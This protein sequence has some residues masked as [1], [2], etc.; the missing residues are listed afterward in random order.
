MTDDLT[1]LADT[2]GEDSSLHV[3]LPGKEDTGQRL[4]RYLAAQFPDVSR[5]VLQ[6]L[7]G[8]ELVT[9]DGVPRRQVFKVTA[10]QVI[11]VTLPEA[12]QTDLIAEPM[13]L[14]VIYQDED[15][16]VLDKPAG[17]VVHPAPGNPSGTLVN[18][19]LHYLPNLQVGGTNRPGIVHR[20]DKETSGVMVVGI[21]DRGHRSL[22]SQWANRTVDKRYTALVRGD[23]EVDQGTID[24][25]IGRHSTDR[26]RMAPQVAGKTAVS[27]FTVL[28]R[29]GD[30]SLVDVELV[31]GRT[32][33]IRVHMTFIGHPVVGDRMYN[34]TSGPF[35]GTGSVVERQFLHASRL[36]FDLPSTGERVTFDSPLPADLAAALADLCRVP[37]AAT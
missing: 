16:L 14:D 35:G 29:F 10:G 37:P 33:Q 36:S 11:Q 9:V 20:L 25:P 23:V 4:D 6:R 27:H 34:R 24:V 15:I 1:P 32:H 21:S 8:T 17:L 31:T 7:I 22:T 19:L 18:G 12:E 28:E 30:A 5:S 26:L 13:S 3:F 2:L